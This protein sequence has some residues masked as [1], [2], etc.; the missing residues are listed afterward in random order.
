MSRCRSSALEHDLSEMERKIL[1]FEAKQDKMV[2]VQCQLQKEFVELSERYP[3]YQAIITAKGETE[4][5][6][7]GVDDYCTTTE[8]G[9]TVEARA[10]EAMHCLES[11]DIRS[12]SSAAL[13]NS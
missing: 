8:G 6:I 5:A 12:A 3:R 2:T 4:G 7:V 10:D 9:V 1:R 13:K 11:A